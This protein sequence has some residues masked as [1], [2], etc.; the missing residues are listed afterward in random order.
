ME[1]I[2]VLVVDDSSLARELIRAILSTDN[3]IVIAGEA[4]NGREAVEMIP[5]L[6]P[7]IVV[8]DIEMPVMNGLEATEMI[9]ASHPVPILVV[10]TRGDA[11]TAYAAISKGALDLILKPD[12]NLNSAREF[13][14][15]I[16]LLSKVRV[17]THLKA[18]RAAREIQVQPKPVPLGKQSDRIVAIASS[19]GGPEA[20]SVILS[21][22]PSNFPCPIVIA[23]HISDGFVAGMVEWLKG[24]SRISIKVAA[25]GEHPVAGAVYVS[26][27][28]MH[29]TLNSSKRIS[30]LERHPKDIYRPSCDALLLSVAKAYGA[31]SIGVI[32]TGMGSDGAVGIRKIKEAGGHTLAQDEK[33]SVVFGM[34]KVAIDSGFV[35][36]VV[37]LDHIADELV[38]FLGKQLERQSG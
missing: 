24:L 18:H 14:N 11:H 12:V 15:K 27:S 26:P 25:E 16:K 22:L 31:N 29:M 2:K 5:D 3:D 9:M 7:N 21:R 10:T 1:K 28:E 33:T 37:P 35:D 30:L 6:Q 34:N 13:I 23:Q 4:A 38:N 17:I 8:M 19:T 36:K 32:L 20:L